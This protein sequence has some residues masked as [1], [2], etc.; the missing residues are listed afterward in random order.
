MKANVFFLIVMEGRGEKE[1]ERER[2]ERAVASGAERLS[3]G[4]SEAA[5]YAAG[6][7]TAACRYTR[8]PRAKED[9][10]LGV[11]GYSESYHFTA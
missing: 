4:H 2:G 7:F 1:N 10:A 9:N 6:D 5:R 11:A 3:V 8:V